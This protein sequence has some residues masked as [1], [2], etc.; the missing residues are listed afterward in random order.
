MRCES[1]GDCDGCRHP[2]GDA[3]AAGRLPGFCPAGIWG[4][5]SHRHD[6]LRWCCPVGW[7]RGRCPTRPYKT[8]GGIECAEGG[9]LQL[10][11]FI[12]FM[13]FGR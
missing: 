5:G 3:L 13:A 9:L 2:Q 10:G 8:A 1:R 11:N 7:R 4:G 6:A 12:Y